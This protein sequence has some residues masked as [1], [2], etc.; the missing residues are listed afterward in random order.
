MAPEFESIIDNEG[1]EIRLVPHGGYVSLMQLND[2]VQ[3]IFKMVKAGK[4][5]IHINYFGDFDPSGVQMFEDIKSRLARIWD[6]RAVQ[7]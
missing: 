7:S 3:R 4:K 5:R 2:S 1:L 6:Y